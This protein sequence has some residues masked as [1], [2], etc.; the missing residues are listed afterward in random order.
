MNLSNS[1]G[2]AQSFS[3]SLSLFS[4][5]TYASYISACAGRRASCEC[6]AT[7]RLVMLCRADWRDT[8]SPRRQRA[9]CHGTREGER[10][11]GKRQ[12]VRQRRRRRRTVHGA[13][14]IRPRQDAHPWDGVRSHV[15]LAGDELVKV[16]RVRGVAAVRADD[17]GGVVHRAL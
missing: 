6:A 12:R 9:S 16:L 10:R 5:H 15:A 3:L 17:A 14:A 2:L 1:F 11:A 8:V 13:H 7:S 4:T